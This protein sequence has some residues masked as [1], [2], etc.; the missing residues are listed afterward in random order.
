MVKHRS[1]V[2]IVEPSDPAVAEQLWDYYSNV[3]LA[4]AEVENL[5]PNTTNITA[6]I[7]AITQV[8]GSADI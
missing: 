1:T 4:F 3:T 6:I 7:D 2:K 8:V 5:H